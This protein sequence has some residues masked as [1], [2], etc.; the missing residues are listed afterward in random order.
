MP[1]LPRRESDEHCAFLQGPHCRQG[2]REF[3]N[4]VSIARGSLAEL[5]TL[6]SLG[7]RLRYFTAEQTAPCLS[8]ADEVGR[9]TTRLLQA[10]RNP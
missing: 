6:L 2:Q 5:E 10:L 3:A 4:F 8:L 9:L 7:E 1:R